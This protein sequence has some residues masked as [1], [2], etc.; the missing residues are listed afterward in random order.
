M[1][2]PAGT[3]FNMS[4]VEAIHQELFEQT[5]SIANAD[6]LEGDLFDRV[7]NDVLDV[8]FHHAQLRPEGVEAITSEKV[9]TDE[10]AEGTRGTSKLWPKRAN[11]FEK[12]LSGFQGKTMTPEV[13]NECAWRAAASFDCLMKFREL[14]QTFEPCEPEWAPMRVED[15]RYGRP[16]LNGKPTLNIVFRLFGGQFGGLTFEQRFPYRFWMAVVKK[17]LGFSVYKRVHKN[18][19]VRVRLAG[20]LDT[21]EQQTQI[22]EFYASGGMRDW[23]RD[24]RKW[25]EDPC[26]EGFTWLCHEC[27]MGHFPAVKNTMSC[28]RGTHTNTYRR[29]HCIRCKNDEAWLDGAARVCVSCEADA[30]RKMVRLASYGG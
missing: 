6:V 3:R 23:N 18:E 12:M 24:L 28:S 15:V 16:T 8:L 4:C 7:V 21:C 30:N 5:L 19:F 26:P 17:D 20:L 14:K 9:T 10:T 22:T 25:R 27:T 1:P 13:M 11:I 29:D 2:P